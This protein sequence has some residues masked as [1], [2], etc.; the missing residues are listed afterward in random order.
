VR[1][2]YWVVGRLRLRKCPEVEAAIKVLKG[3]WRLGVGIGEFEPGVIDL[4]MEEGDLESWETGQALRDLIASLDPY[5][6]EPAVLTSEHS[7]QEDA[8]IVAATDEARC[9]AYS[10]HAL[11]VIT[12]L[13][14]CL[15][16]RDRA[17]LTALAANGVR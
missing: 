13:M 11:N 5:V 1:S 9:E 15:T 7:L 2:Y 17:L 12:H 10:G 3:D 4:E 6:L 16:P 8:L 14:R